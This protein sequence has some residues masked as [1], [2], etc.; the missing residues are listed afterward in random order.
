[1]NHC[2]H[3]IC[4]LQYLYYTYTVYLYISN[5]TVTSVLQSKLILCTIPYH[6]YTYN[7]YCISYL[8]IHVNYP[9]L[10]VTPVN[11]CRVHERVNLISSYRGCDS[12]AFTLSKYWVDVMC[13]LLH[14]CLICVK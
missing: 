5:N 9:K 3:V 11:T 13:I 14:I 8:H 4:I 10:F 12:C 6:K 7:E 2:V 1:M